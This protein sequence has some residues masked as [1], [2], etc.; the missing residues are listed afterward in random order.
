MSE[1]RTCT[2]H[3]RGKLT[4]P[5]DRAASTKLDLSLFPQTAIIYGALAMVEGDAKYGGF[6]WRLA[7]VKASVYVAAAQRHLFKWFNGQQSDEKTNVPH[8]ASALAC[9]AILVDAVEC[10]KLDDDRPP[11][12]DVAAILDDFEQVVKHIH[13]LYP[14]GPPRVTELVDG[15]LQEAVDDAGWHDLFDPT[16]E[17]DGGL[18]ECRVCGGAEGSLPTECPGQEMDA[19]QNDDVYAGRLDFIGGYWVVKNPFAEADARADRP[20]L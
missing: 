9:L 19:Q 8:L 1:T 6:N 17:A 4:N 15:Q 3:N 12:C 11:D 18:A 13:D 20:G 10:G 14:D 7:G 2:E 5:K 16:G